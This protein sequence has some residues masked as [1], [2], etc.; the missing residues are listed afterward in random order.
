MTDARYMR[1]GLPFATGKLVEEI[2]ELQTE[3]G[4]VQ[5]KLGHLSQALGKTLRW[6][7][8]SSNPELPVLKRESN[9]DWIN[10]AIMEVAPTLP[11]LMA[12]LAD[13]AEAAVHYLKEYRETI[14]DR[15]PSCGG[16]NLS[17]PDGCQRDPET[18]ELIDPNPAP[19]PSS[20]G[21]DQFGHKVRFSDSSL[22]DEVCTLCGGT[23]AMGDATLLNPCAKA[24]QEPKF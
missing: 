24:N 14:P 7:P 2:G 15:C 5:S 19:A 10:R 8:D 1:S 3:L 16:L 13:Y 6:G 22:Y 18:G 11:P 23:D 9:Q 17:C 20:L 4:N 12:E 21:A